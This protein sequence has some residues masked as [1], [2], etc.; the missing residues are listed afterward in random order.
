MVHSLRLTIKGTW[1][2][3]G[4]VQKNTFLTF[5]SLQRWCMIEVCA[6]DALATQKNVI[7]KCKGGN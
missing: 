5:S 7:D 2:I 6:N 4:Q 1:E 3:A